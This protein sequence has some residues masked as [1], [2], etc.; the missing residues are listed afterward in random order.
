MIELQMGLNRDARHKRL[1]A[2]IE[3]RCKQGAER[4]YVLVPEQ[5]EFN[6]I[7]EVLCC[8]GNQLTN[9]CVT[10]VGFKQ[11]YERIFSKYGG[12][13]ECLDA[14]ERLLVMAAAV[15][16]EKNNLSV[17]KKSAKDPGFLQA[18]TSKYSTMALQGISAEKLIDAA[19]KA[20]EKYWAKKVADMVKIFKTYHRLCMES[21]PDPAHTID[22]VINIIEEQEW[23]TGT[24]WFIDGFVDFP[25]RQMDLINAIL[26]RA[27]SVLISLAAESPDDERLSSQTSA[28]TARAIIAMLERNN[29][30]S[31]I[32]L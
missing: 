10:V 1:M 23:L 21:K 11:L 8:V 15:D 31:V 13:C 7:K 26:S 14:G 2:E 25:K 17:Y 29:H 5:A 24:H 20:S 4:I 18:L 12:R 9:R 28:R 3:R 30:V 16:E 22:R 32:A 27:E 19:E 6:M